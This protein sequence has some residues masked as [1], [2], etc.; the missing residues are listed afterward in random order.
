MESLTRRSLL[1]TSTL[2]LAAGVLPESTSAIPAPSGVPSKRP[3]YQHLTVLGALQT[4][5]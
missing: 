3:A 4:W 1:K 5:G 2:A